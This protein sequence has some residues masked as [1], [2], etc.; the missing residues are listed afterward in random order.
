MARR[1]IL[2]KTSEPENAAFEQNMAV[3]RMETE[4]A[5]RLLARLDLV[6]KG[7]EAD[8]NL[9]AME[10]WTGSVEFVSSSTLA[11]LV[12]NGYDDSDEDPPAD[13]ERI[14]SLVESAFDQGQDLVLVDDPDEVM[15]AVDDYGEAEDDDDTRF[16]CY[17]VVITDDS[18]EWKALAKYGSGEGISTHR[19]TE[20]HV[21]WLAGGVAPAEEKVEASTQ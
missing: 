14:A 12:R 7:K 19:L 18:F 10:Y 8:G 16:D 1:F 20:A 17:T 5:E 6:K 9:Y 2:S 11:E 15:A 21:R 3:I 4:L 13:V